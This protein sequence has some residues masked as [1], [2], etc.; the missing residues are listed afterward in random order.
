MRLSGKIHLSYQAI[1]F[2]VNEVESWRNNLKVSAAM[3]PS[4]S[5]YCS[6]SIENFGRTS[7]R[8]VFFV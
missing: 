5:A 4:E 6:F 3:K 8:R 2:A 1:D 7:V